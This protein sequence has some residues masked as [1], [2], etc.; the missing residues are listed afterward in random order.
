M[1]CG[2]DISDA[3]LSAAPAAHRIETPCQHTFCGSCFTDG[4]IHWHP[5]QLQC[6]QCS[7]S[8]AFV[9]KTRVRTSASRTTRSAKKGRVAELITTTHTFGHENDDVQCE[10]KQGLKLSWQYCY[11]DPDPEAGGGV[12]YTDTE[13]CTIEEHGDRRDPQNHNSGIECIS[14]FWLSCPL[15]LSFTRAKR[16]KLHTRPI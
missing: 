1:A 5:L 7:E 2:M 9:K 6:E 4:L 15:L 8:V 3:V 16:V 13:S 12:L 14:R 10:A 11:S